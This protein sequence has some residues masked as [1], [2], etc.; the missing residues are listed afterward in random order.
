[1]NLYDVRIENIGFLN[2]GPTDAALSK[3]DVTRLNR[4]A[5]EKGLFPPGVIRVVSGE[6]SEDDGQADTNIKVFISVVLRVEATSAQDAENIDPPECLLDLASDAIDD[7]L[8]REAQWEVLDSEPVQV[9][10]AT[11]C[12]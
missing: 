1:M 12:T 3:T 6:L 4:D 7:T 10:E 11:L 5:Q 9:Q 8:E 2:G